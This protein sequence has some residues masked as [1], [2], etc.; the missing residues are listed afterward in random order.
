MKTHRVTLCTFAEAGEWPGR[1]H[2]VDIIR[3]SKEISI[4]ISGLCQGWQ[5][6][7]RR[8]EKRTTVLL[9]VSCAAHHRSHQSV[10]PNKYAL[11]CPFC[12]S[13]VVFVV[14]YAPQPLLKRNDASY[15]TQF[16]AFMVF[17]ERLCILLNNDFAQASARRRRDFCVVFPCSCLQLLILL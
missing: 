12:L 1:G 16:H 8:A 14:C 5:A 4:Y 9:K 17:K 7:A 13:F 3:G 10:T 15:C 11:I 6:G 2:R